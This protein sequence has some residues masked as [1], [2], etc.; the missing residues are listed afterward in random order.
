MDI[1]KVKLT[2]NRVYV[3][4]GSWWSK[5]SPSQLSLI[6]L[7]GW[8]ITLGMKNTQLSWR[9]AVGNIGQ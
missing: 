9:A 6:G 8:S 4:L 3:G 7:C 1:K 2:G 5:G